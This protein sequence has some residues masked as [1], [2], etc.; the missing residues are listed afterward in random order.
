M[1]IYFA[2]SIRAGRADVDIYHD[3]IK[4]LDRYG[5]VLTE[6]VGRR[7]ILPMG[8]ALPEREIFERD[9]GW[10]MQADA[11]V[12]EVSTPSLGVGFEI[13]VA[14]ATY[15]KPVLCVWRPNGERTLSAMIAGNPRLT[16]QTY[17]L[18]EDLPTVFDVFFSR[19]NKM[20]R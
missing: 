15:D 3:I 9:L 20:R 18:V 4:I 5:E 11:L 10:L 16:V 13:G 8:D 1:T 7:D 19:V 14:S 12:A 2:G 6:H 17:D